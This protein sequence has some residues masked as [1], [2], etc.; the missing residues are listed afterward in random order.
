MPSPTEETSRVAN[1]IKIG[2]AR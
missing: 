1:N 2:K